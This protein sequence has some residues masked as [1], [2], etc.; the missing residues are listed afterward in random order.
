MVPPI[1]CLP[2]QVLWSGFHHEIPGSSI[3]GRRQHPK[4]VPGHPWEGSRRQQGWN[5]LT[6]AFGQLLPESVFNNFSLKQGFWTDLIL[7]LACHYHCLPKLPVLCS[8][9][10]P[11][12][13]ASHLYPAVNSGLLPP[14][15]LCTGSFVISSDS[16]FSLRSVILPGWFWQRKPAACVKLQSWLRKGKCSLYLVYNLKA[17]TESCKH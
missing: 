15:R 14:T 13:S 2:A 5:E 4:V 3:I 7:F 8:R 12:A 10:Q 9:A 16:C 6:T 11:T 17:H 1:C